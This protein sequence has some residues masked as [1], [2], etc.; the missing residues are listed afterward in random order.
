MN[1]KIKTI[2]PVLIAIMILQL[3]GPSHIFMVDVQA[4]A[5]VL[6]N[7]D[8]TS[9]WTSGNALSVDTTDKQEGTGSLKAIGSQTVWFQKTFS[10]AVNTTVTESNG[11]LKLWLYI[12]DVTKFS[13]GGQI[14]I[15]SSGT[16]DTDEYSWSIPGLS[17][18]NGWNELNLKIS[19]ATRTGSPD[20]SA[21]NFIRIYQLVSESTTFKVDYIKFDSVLNTP[22]GEAIKLENTNNNTLGWTSDN[23]LSIDTI[24]KKK[25]TGSL[26][27]EG[28]Q[29]VW[30]KKAFSPGFNT[31]VDESNG[32]MKLWLYVSD[33]T[34][35][36]GE[37]QI[38][39]SSS[40][41]CDAD[42]Y[43]WSIT[44]FPLSNGWNELNLKISNATRIGNP[45]LNAITYI[46]IYKG[47]TDSI[48]TKLDYIRFDTIPVLDNCDSTSG[49]TS[50]NTLSVDTTDKQEGTGSLN[51]VGSQTV[52]FQKTFSTA[53]D[54]TVI[55]SNGY[56]KL[57]LYV[58]DVTKFSGGGQIEITSSGISD[59]DEYSWSISGLSLSNGWNELDLKISNATKTGN[60]DLSAVNFIRIYQ[61]VSGSTTFKIDYIKF[62]AVSVMDNCDSISGWASGNTLSLD[63][64]DM[65][66]GTGS[67]KAVGSQTVWFQKTF[68]QIINTGVT[69]SNGN[70]KLWLYVSDVSKLSVGGQIEITS[71]GRSDAD[72]Y[73]WNIPGLSLSN[74]WNELE[75]KIDKAIKVGNPD[76][77]AINFIRIYHFLSDSIT[78]RI[79][80]LRF[81]TTAV[82]DNCDSI[83]NVI[84]YSYYNVFST[85]TYTFQSGDYIEYDVKILNNV[86]G[87]GGIDIV[88][89]D[90]TY[91]RDAANWYD[92]NGIGG[93]PGSD[94][95]AL[96]YNTWYHR[97]LA[98]PG[99]MIGKQVKS[100]FG[101]QCSRQI[102][103]G[104]MDPG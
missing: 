65:Q 22:S 71:S 59:V 29:Q 25:G 8:S 2:I 57:W 30:F 34:K 35:L 81:D 41:T 7:C 21:I 62:D 77:G 101:V 16:C 18:S 90:N 28:S 98:V 40:G 92:Q 73:G 1:K 84:D 31:G 69:E 15:T 85:S 55:E 24:D 88:N 12:S 39:I 20:L 10:T 79:D 99:T 48:T 63:T 3:F 26:K 33:A 87:A 5:V 19:N 100:R 37:G 23:T 6:D 83:G 43:N 13:G 91:F 52:W 86:S 72:E 64:T 94:I 44:A 51:A 89:T 70:F 36:S 50:G 17:L 54:T 97:M 76:L 67:L 78:V 42:E 14:E 49:W 95:K 61:L 11:Y 4:S 9:G 38:E 66:E 103:S 68:S 58:S 93:N 80:N 82:M 75:L 102:H 47:L 45:N 32:Y 53:V 96:A 74:G 60:P 27:A 56:L 46:R 104:H